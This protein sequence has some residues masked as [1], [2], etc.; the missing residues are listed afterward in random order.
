MTQTPRT[1][2]R[3]W[4]I[5]HTRRVDNWHLKLA[6]MRGPKCA[7]CRLLG[8]QKDTSVLFHKH[9]AGLTR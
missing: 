2:P 9:D 1:A 8:L 3:H 4:L 6:A 5:S 7:R